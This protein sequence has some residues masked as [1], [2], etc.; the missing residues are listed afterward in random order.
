MPASPAGPSRRT[1]LRGLAATVALPPLESLLPRVARAAAAAAPPPRRF[2]AV[3]STLGIYGPNFFPTRVGRAFDAP[4]YLA[5]LAGHR[6]QY[7]VF[8]GLHHPEVDGGHESERCFLTA[9]P[10][11]ARPG[12]RNGVS[13]DQVI[14]EAVGADTRFASLVL[15]TSYEGNVGLSWTR[16][17]VMIPADGRPSRVFAKLFTGGTP[18]EAK[19]Q[20]DRIRDGKSVLDAVK[21]QAEK[22]RKSAGAADR[23]KLD[24]YFEAVREVEGKLQ[25]A[26][27]WAARPLPKPPGPAPVDAAP[28]ADLI[29]RARLMFDLAALALRTD[30]TR[31]VT[32]NVQGTGFVVPL[33]GVSAH[34]HEL[35]HHGKD[36]EKLKQ[37]AAVEGELFKLLGGFADALAKTAEGDATLLDRTAVL[38]GSNL[39]NANN[40]DTRNLPILVVGGGFK[41]AGH[42]AFAGDTAP[43]L[44]SLFVSIARQTGAAVKGFGPST[45]TL[46]GFEPTV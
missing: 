12:F 23:P 13:V 37:L 24:E 18:A 10:H 20:A 44:S 25:K 22:A 34:H 31:V 11:P 4:E 43:P 39:G 29:T 9:V 30:S 38:V 41:H 3:C 40:H 35:S 42:V 5:A 26:G 21:A 15:N 45:S 36:P 19:A 33:P 28:P 7:T 17:G 8:S 6:G 2:V 14:A 16:N 27:A 46:R 32:L 1:V